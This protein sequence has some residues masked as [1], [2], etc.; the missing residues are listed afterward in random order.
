M[1]ETETQKERRMKMRKLFLMM[2]IAVCMSVW[3]ITAVA[4]PKKGGT[5]KVGVPADAVGLDPHKTRAYSSA[6]MLKTIYEELVALSQDDN[7][8]P[9]LAK[10]WTI[11]ESRRG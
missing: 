6:L 5:L 7:V 4:A 3:A 1:M 11:S 10:S 2:L 8:M 9:G